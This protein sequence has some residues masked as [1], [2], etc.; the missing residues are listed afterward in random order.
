MQFP[1][2]GRRVARRQTRL[3]KACIKSCTRHLATE[4]PF[5]G[6]TI[7]LLTGLD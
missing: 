2:K 4:W 1:N 3:V 7:T 5:E 6:L